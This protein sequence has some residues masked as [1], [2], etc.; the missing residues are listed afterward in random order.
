MPLGDDDYY[1]V[2]PET[3]KNLLRPKWQ[4]NYNENSI[5]HTDAVNFLCKK[6]PGFHPAL[7]KTI[8]ASKTDE[9]L[10]KRNEVIY[11]NFVKVYGRNGEDPEM[12]AAL[13]ISKCMGRQKNRKI[14]VS[15]LCIL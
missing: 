11:K 8:L 10:L 12:R 5:W 3:G 1:L 15:H 6:G 14:R 9:E 2:D 4:D 13:K 7:T